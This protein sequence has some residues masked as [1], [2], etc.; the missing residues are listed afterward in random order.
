VVEMA[1]ADVDSQ[2]GVSQRLTIDAGANLPTASLLYRT[3]AGTGSTLAIFVTDDVTTTRVASAPTGEGGWRQL[4]GDVT[5]WVGKTVTL[6]VSLLQPAG[7]LGSQV[8]VDEVSLGSW[9]T[10]HVTSVAPREVSGIGP[11]EVTLIGEN[12]FE[13]TIVKVDDAPVPVAWVDPHTVIITVPEGLS[14]GLHS[15]W[16]LNPA[17]EVAVLRGVLR[18]GRGTF[19]PVAR[20]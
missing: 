7:Q 2:S 19:L 4:W 9:T 10:P 20:R 11:T 13:A 12:L 8:V 6:T 17:G 18:V 1:R 16:V 3:D 15:I 5:P 14:L